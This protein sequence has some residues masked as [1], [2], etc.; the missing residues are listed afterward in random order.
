MA[1]QNLEARVEHLE[2]VVAELQDALRAIGTLGPNA[3]LKAMDKYAGDEG[4]QAVFAEGKKLREADRAR[5]R[6]R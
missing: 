2:A 4:L 1:A 5:A 3:W 6:R